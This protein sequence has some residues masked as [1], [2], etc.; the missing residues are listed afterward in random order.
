MKSLNTLARWI[1]VSSADPSQVALTI[2][3]GLVFL[4]PAA[5]ALSGLTHIN[6]GQDQLNMLIDGLA[7]VV[8]AV[9]T[10]VSAVMVFVGMVRK[11]WI[12]IHTHQAVVTG[13]DTPTPPAPSQ[14]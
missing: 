3:G 8:Q 12:T 7:S 4:V 5:M 2:K 6:V 9:L 11:L 10:V 14:Q 13:T 1:V